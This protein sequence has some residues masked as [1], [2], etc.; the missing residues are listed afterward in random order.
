MK[1]LVFGTKSYDKISFEKELK[2]YPD[3]QVNFTETNLTPLTAT[4]AQGYKAVCGFVNSD[5]SAMTLEVLRGLGVELVLMRC[6]GFDAVNVDFA[7]S[8]G[9]ANRHGSYLD[10]IARN[11]PRHTV[12]SS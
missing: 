5:I 7:K 4:L 9:V 10:V 12:T 6:A 8:V 3:L 2:D 11:T 1:I